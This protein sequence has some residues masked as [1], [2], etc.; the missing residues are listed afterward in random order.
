LFDENDGGGSNNTK[1][2]SKTNLTPLWILLGVS[3]AG[4]GL[5]LA[6]RK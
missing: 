3:V 2:N 1:D 5:Y 6:T 4:G